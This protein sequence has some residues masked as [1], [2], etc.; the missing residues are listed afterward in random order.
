M[1]SFQNLFFYVYTTMVEPIPYQYWQEN[2]KEML[3]VVPLH[4][5]GSCAAHY[6]N[7]GKL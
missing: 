6:L 7:K 2:S 4:A 5:P 1:T 3:G